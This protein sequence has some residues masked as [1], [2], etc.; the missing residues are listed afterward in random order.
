MVSNPKVSVIFVNIFG[1]I[2]KCDVIAEGIVKAAEEL[3]LEI[4]LIVRMKGTNEDLGKEILDK[5]ALK[6]QSADDMES[7]AKMSVNATNLGA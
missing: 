1:G 2:M 5:S 7:A 4:P 6:I 3:N